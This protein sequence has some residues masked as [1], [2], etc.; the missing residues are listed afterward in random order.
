MNEEDRI[1]KKEWQPSHNHQKTKEFCAKLDALRKRGYPSLIVIVHIYLWYVQYI[2]SNYNLVVILYKITNVPQYWRK[3]IHRWSN[4][5]GLIGIKTIWHPPQ[6]DAKESTSSILRTRNS[7]RGLQRPLVK[8]LASWN[9]VETCGRLMTFRSYSSWI[10]WQSPS[11]G[12]VHSR[13]IGFSV[14]RTALVLSTWRRL[15]LIRGIPNSISNPQSHRISKQGKDMAWY[16]DFVEG[17]ETVSCFLHF[18]EIKAFA[19]KHTPTC[20]RM[21]SIR[22]L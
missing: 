4:V 18:Q 14:M 12:F 9:S 15:A 17:I 19:Q 10:K 2:I 7:W 1:L 21:P 22:I 3:P 6:I 20:S 5:M 8:M 11:I 16:S 13:K